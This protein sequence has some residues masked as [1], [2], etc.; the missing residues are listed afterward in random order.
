MGPLIILTSPSLTLQ[1]LTN[2][3]ITFSSILALE[4]SS[5]VQHYYTSLPLSLLCRSPSIRLRLFP[6]V[7]FSE[8][9]TDNM[10][11]SVNGNSI[12]SSREGTSSESERAKEKKAANADAARKSRAGKKTMSRS[13]DEQYLVLKRVEEA[14][15]ALLNQKRAA[16]QALRESLLHHALDPDCQCLDLKRQLRKS[17]PQPNVGDLSSISLV[18]AFQDKVSSSIAEG[19][20]S[21]E[22]SSAMKS[23]MKKDMEILARDARLA[24]SKTIA[25][26]LASELGEW[27]SLERALQD[28]AYSQHCSVFRN[29]SLA[30]QSTAW[31]SFSLRVI[32]G[33]KTYHLND[34]IEQRIRGFP[35]EDDRL[36]RVITGESVETELKRLNFD[37][38]HITA[39]KREMGLE[40]PLATDDQSQLDSMHVHATFDSSHLSGP[41]NAMTDFRREIQQPYTAIEE[42]R[43]QPFTENVNF[44]TQQ[45][46]S[47]VNSTEQL[48]ESANLF[49][50]QQQAQEVVNNFNFQTGFYQS[51][52]LPNASDSLGEPLGFPTVS[53]QEI[54]SC[55]P[56]QSHLPETVSVNCNMGLNE[57]QHTS[58]WDSMQSFNTEGYIPETLP[59]APPSRAGIQPNELLFPDVAFNPHP[60]LQQQQQQQDPQDPQQSFYYHI[61]QQQEQQQASLEEQAVPYE[62][63]DFVDFTDAQE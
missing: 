51:Q 16:V 11:T 17:L 55:L 18:Q 8:D 7:R 19:E 28:A 26:S 49:N 27:E 53:N 63:D 61:F 41:F 6:L 30:P 5:I 15:V 38:Y 39:V 40:L 36:K 58:S 25:P 47:R 45:G 9:S 12:L 37:H 56:P 29:A 4:D 44:N 35:M 43:Q 42:I 24:M 21:E 33:D 32:M 3:Q 34:P 13:S 10:A 46:L 57:F 23:K 62:F 60:L 2:S 20:L 31:S 52:Q 48:P 54:Q 22:M 1:S 59:L 50:Q 14:L